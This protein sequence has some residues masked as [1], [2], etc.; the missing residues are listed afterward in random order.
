MRH[1][2]ESLEGG[3]SGRD[4]GAELLIAGHVNTPGGEQVPQLRDGLKP[5]RTHCG[6]GEVGVWVDATPK[7]MIWEHGCPPVVGLFQILQ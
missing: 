1:S 4:S 2:L 5:E 7:N 3:Q 6:N